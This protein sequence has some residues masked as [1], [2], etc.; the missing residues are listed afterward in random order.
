MSGFFGVASENDCVFDLFF[1][2]DYHSHLGTKKGGMAVYGN[3]GFERSI[4]DI[5]NS[6][7]RTKFE[8]DIHDMSGNLG[9]G[10]ISDNEPQPLIVRSHLGNFAITTVGRINNT[11]ELVGQLFRDGTPH[12]LAMSGGDINP[13][14][15]VA[16][17]INMKPTIVEGIRY[18]QQKIDGS[19]SLLIMTPECLYAARD[20]YGRTPVFIGK[21]EGSYC[22]AVESSSYLNLGYTD[23]K[24]LG[25]AEIVKVTKDK[26]DIVAPAEK[27][28]K[29]CT[30]M[31]V[32]YGYPSSTY[33]G[34]NV[35]EMRYRCGRALAKRDDV[36]PDIVAGIPDSGTPSAIG[37][38]QQSGINF[39]RPFIK[40]TQT[41]L[42]SFMPQIQ[43][44]REFV[45][46]MKLI[47]IQSLI[48]DKK[49][50]LVD[51]SIV[52]GTQM[53][54]TAEFLYEHGARE[55]HVRSSCPPIMF[56]CRYLNFSRSTSDMDLIARR[57][58]AEKGVKDTESLAPYLNSDTPEYAQMVNDISAKLNFTSLRYNRLDDLVAATGLNECDL[59]TYCW[60]GKK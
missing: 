54:D 40:Y 20:Y 57:V 5:S 16:S 44:Q 39:S 35:E 7:F 53:R 43:T 1:G 4:H 56:G 9:I 49:L 32:Y 8:K 24:E 52:R 37:Y 36:S 47:P 13:T 6:P 15:L 12:F 25:P 27:T 33:E 21:K 58:V 55:V 42:R 51:D 26:T 28:K 30:F 45:A 50:L 2:I 38:S 10:C 22:V 46:K 17:L 41:W 59:C 19:M 34:V 11:D 29:M 14:E 3:T 60:N 18:A 23:L 31:W 48:T